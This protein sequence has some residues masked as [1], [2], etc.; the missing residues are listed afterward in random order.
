MESNL[1]S[2]NGRISRSTFWERW[3]VA[4][5][6]DIPIQ[7]MMITDPSSKI[8]CSIISLIIGVFVII[9]WIKR[10]HDID[11]S[12][13][14]TVIPIYGLIL[15]FRDGTVGNNKYGENPKEKNLQNQA[16][17]SNLFSINGRIRCSTFWAR[18][19]VAIVIGVFIQF[20]AI[21]DPSVKILC[22]IINWII[23]VF[24]I[25]Q[26]IKRMHDIDKSGWFTIIPIYGL[27]LTFRDGTVG[28]NRYGENPKE[29]K[30]QNQALENSIMILLISAFITCGLYAII[31]IT[32]I[33][34]D[35]TAKN[36]IFVIS[37]TVC[38]LLG[39]SLKEQT[40]I[41]NEDKV[42]NTNS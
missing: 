11:K 32:K 22:L 1:F 13:W 5:V 6:I 36:S 29:K 9:Q 19:I 40:K 17:E 10:M 33:I 31:T 14:F 38:N 4:F 26:W 24:V 7:I 37:F 20:M 25:I 30:P 28:N 18:W 21:E 3:I 15:T 12:G 35:E 2:I 23:G 41:T 34:N 27:I 8:L 42:A 16:L 39:L